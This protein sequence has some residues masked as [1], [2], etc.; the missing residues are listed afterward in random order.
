MRCTSNVP[1]NL[2]VSGWICSR[3]VMSTCSNQLRVLE[4]VHGGACFVTQ[5][6][7]HRV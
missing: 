2:I 7:Q 3:C 5:A 4:D 1:S 6:D